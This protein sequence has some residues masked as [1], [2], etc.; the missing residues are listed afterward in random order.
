MTRKSTNPMK[1]FE[2]IKVSAPDR[3]LFDM[4]H[5]VKFT[6]QIGNL[7]PIMCI[8]TLPG[9]N[10]EIGFDT[11]VRFPPVISPVMHRFDVYIHA[12]FVPN[13]I[14]WRGW[15]DFIAQ[16]D[17]A[18]TLPKMEI[19]AEIS[20]DEQKF[21]DY[22]G[23]PPWA[24]SPQ[25]ASEFI[26][27][28]PFGAYQLIYN[29]YYRA[30]QLISEVSYLM[31]DAGGTLTDGQRDALLFL[32]KRA[33]EHDYFTSCLPTP[34]IGDAQVIPLGDVV[35]KTDWET[36]GY[37]EFW[38]T[39][40]I[41][42]DG[43][44]KSAEAVGDIWVDGPVSDPK[45]AYNPMGTLSVGAT[46][47]N[48]LREAYALQRFLEKINRSGQRYYEFVRAIWGE[49]PSDAR[50][51]RPEY[52]TGMKAPVMITEVLNQTSIAAEDALGYQ[53][54]HMVSIGSGRKERFYTEDYG[55]VIAIMSVV[56]KPAYMQGISRHW[57]KE[58]PW[59]FG[60]PDFANIGEQAV[61]TRE[62]YAFS[63][64]QSEEFG[65]IPRFSE[66]KYEPSRVAGE[67]RTTLAT[68]QCARNF[69]AAPVLNQEFIEVP[70]D[71]ADHIFAVGSFTAD[72]L[73][74][75]VLNSL[76]IARKLPMYGTPI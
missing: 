21:L 12:F 57:T 6:G 9:D 58:D 35:L 71:I 59:E 60:I 55:Y 24:T 1:M 47:I 31:P 72:Q 8:P 64:E 45:V 62:L 25:Q 42:P 10:I 17:G 67:F 32:R 52:I 54:G 19:N 20:T 38:T 49:T 27:A 74:C 13:R 65:Y 14:V 66:Y 40:D 3:N 36:Y 48:Q 63:T 70:N 76:K 2:E 73:W 29:E 50:L 39:A 53:G 18:G 22:F 28:I 5:D 11:L 15:E 43:T 30:Q 34:Q 26:Q 7:I 75:N 51:Q 44:V 56:P 61:L 68:Y 4:T 23:I 46:T 37:P 69:G 41:S 16:V 33:W